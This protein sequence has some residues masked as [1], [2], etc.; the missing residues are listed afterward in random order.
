MPSFTNGPIS[1]TDTQL[2]SSDVLLY[3]PVSFLIYLFPHLHIISLDIVTY[4]HTNFSFSL[5]NAI[6]LDYFLLSFS[7]VLFFSP[8]NPHRFLNVIILYDCI[9]C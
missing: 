3:L 8:Q 6:F 1:K 4:L 7:L 9:L 5:S 2:Y